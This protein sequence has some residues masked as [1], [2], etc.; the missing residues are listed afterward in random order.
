MK[1]TAG[2]RAR[3]SD[4][5]NGSACRG[6]LA[7]CARPARL[8]TTIPSPLSI[9]VPWQHARAGE[10]GELGVSP[11]PDASCSLRRFFAPV[12]CRRSWSHRAKETP[13][14]TRDKR[15][16]SDW[17]EFGAGGLRGLLRCTKKGSRF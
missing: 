9:E 17:E 14:V 13:P 7:A 15:G 16:K 8:P 11:W 10:A 2:L 12:R 6:E 3:P 1:S 5:A 4:V